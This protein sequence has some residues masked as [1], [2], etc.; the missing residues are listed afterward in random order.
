[1]SSISSNQDSMW[2]GGV[3]RPKTFKHIHDSQSQ[4]VKQLQLF[5]P[6][7][8]VRVCVRAWG[9]GGTESEE[10][11]MTQQRPPRPHRLKLG[12]SLHTPP[13]VYVSKPRPFPQPYFSALF[14]NQDNFI[15]TL[16]RYDS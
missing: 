7:M 16:Y 12:P 15:D 11:A 5:P 9:G 14:P 13:F 8:V 3:R 4:E 1:M 10:D 6:H 2:M